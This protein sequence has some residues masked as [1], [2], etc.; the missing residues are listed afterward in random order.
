VTITVQVQ[1]QNGFN[2]VTLDTLYDD[3]ANSQIVQADSSHFVAVDTGAFNGHGKPIKFDV[4]GTNLSYSTGPNGGSHLVGGEITGL[5][6]LDNFDNVLESWS[7]PTSLPTDFHLLATDFDAALTRYKQGHGPSGDNNP[8]PTLLD[9]IFKNVDYHFIGGAGS[10]AFVG[11]NLNDHLLGGPGADVLNGG[12]NED[13]AEYTNSSVGL[14]ADLSN[15]LNNTGDAAGDTYISIER[16]RGGSGNDHLVGDGNI[17]HLEGGPGADTLDGRGGLDFAKYGSATIG[18][19][20]SLAD[21]SVN[22][23]DAAGDVYLS[24]EGLIGSSFSDILIGDSSDNQLDGGSS[25]IVDNTGHQIGNGNSADVLNGGQGFD[26]ARYQTFSPNH[27]PHEHV[28]GITASLADP[29]INTFDAKGDTYISI[30]GLIGSDFDDTL[31]GDAGNNRL[32][33]GLGSDKLTGGA[34]ADIFIME[35]D[36]LHDSQASPAFVDEIT[37]YNAKEGDQVDLTLAISSAGASPSAVAVRVVPAATGAILQID[38]DGAANG[39]NWLSMA[40]LD[41]LHAGDTVNV[42]LDPAAPAGQ[43]VTVQQLPQTVHWSA[44]IDVGPHPAGWQPAGIAD[45]NADGTSDLA[46]FNA[47]TGDIDIWKLS[48]GTWAGSVDTGSHPPGYQPVGFGDY[49]H[50]GM[51]DILWFNPSTSDVDLWKMSNGQWTGS[52][53]IGTHPAG[54]VPAASGDFNGDGTADVV[55]FNPSTHDV[56]LWKISNGQWAGSIDIGAHPAGYQLSLTGDF[57][58]DGNRDIAWFNPTTGDVD[59]WKLVNGQWS[60]SIDVGSH[61][62]GWQPLGAA[63]FN[64]DGTSD[65]AWYNPTTNDVEI[66]AMNGGH[67]AGTFDI[68]VHPAGS[69]PVGIGDFDHNGVNDIMWQNTSN[70]HI[71]NWMLA[72]S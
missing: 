58:G 46:W 3:I 12:P 52:V 28:V 14:T 15:Q 53:D 38:L 48:S 11:A 21:P 9:A 49:N 40:N 20:A 17:N 32:V 69:T 27:Q 18:V 50:D 39:Q 23:G 71:E 62:A 1:T 72:F 19:T 4:H 51:H 61:P 55:W 10:D 35:S 63:D 24:I 70:G 68:G 42:I 13:T 54:Y 31:I 65:I 60:A 64:K 43:V 7:W 41:G 36:A 25:A 47:T 30:E 67:W 45:F 44:S 33:G 5:N 37:D 57:T 34:G 26:Y 29:S 8:D 66:W 22:T 16:L 2:L 6:I 59:I 56:D